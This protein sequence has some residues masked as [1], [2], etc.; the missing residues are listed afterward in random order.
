MSPSAQAVG[1]TMC[2]VDKGLL[3]RDNLRKCQDGMQPLFLAGFLLSA[4]LLTHSLSLN[5]TC[6]L[7]ACFAGEKKCHH[8]GAIV[9]SGDLP[10]LPLEPRG[11]LRGSESHPLWG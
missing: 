2:P 5:K 4:L 7:Q 6:N 8:T 3:P 10:H 1:S 9:L 11:V